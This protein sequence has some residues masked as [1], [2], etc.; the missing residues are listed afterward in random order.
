MP[1]FLL[2]QDCMRYCAAV[3]ACHYWSF[4]VTNRVCRMKDADAL[5]GLHYAQNFMSGPKECSDT[6]YSGKN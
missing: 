1:L 3:P 4:D 6:L 2:F 5:G